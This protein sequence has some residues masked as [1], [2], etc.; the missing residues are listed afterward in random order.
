MEKGG[1]AVGEHL[2]Y[3]LDVSRWATHKLD[4]NCI[5]EV[6]PQSGSNLILKPT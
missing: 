6:L 4:I 5:T 1:G 3:K 2:Q